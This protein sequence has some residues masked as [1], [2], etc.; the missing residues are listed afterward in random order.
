V[1]EGWRRKAGVEEGWRKKGWS[2]GK[3][4]GEGKAWVE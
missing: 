2:R 4:A 3:E 1:E